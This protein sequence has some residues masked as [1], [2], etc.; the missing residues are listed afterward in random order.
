[1][2]QR[3]GYREYLD[4]K[5]W[6]MAPESWAALART[7]A[8]QTDDSPALAS[9]AVPTLVVVGELDEPFVAPSNALA[10]TIPGAEFLLVPEAG[11]SPLFENPSVFVPAVTNFLR[12]ERSAP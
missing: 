4:G 1:L 7:I 12:A 3:P 8:H 10:S 2:E 5:F 11:H 9:L 6:A